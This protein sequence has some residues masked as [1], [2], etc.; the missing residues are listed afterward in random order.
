[1]NLLP[2]VLSFA[3]GSALEVEA[4]FSRQSTR[5]DIVRAA[6]GGEE[7]VQR[8]FVGDVYRCQ[9]KAPLALVAVE[10]IVFAERYI[11]EIALGDP[12]PVL[13]LPLRARCLNPK[14]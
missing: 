9:A 13:V 14:R 12:P 11:E 8:V 5:C 1:M 6:E 10:E 4:Y 3:D 2:A 7:V